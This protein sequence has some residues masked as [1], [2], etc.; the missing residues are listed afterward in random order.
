MCVKRSLFPLSSAFRTGEISTVLFHMQAHTHTA[1]TRQSFISGSLEAGSVKAVVL[2]LA[3][4]Y[5]KGFTHLSYRGHGV[6]VTVVLVICTCKDENVPKT[7]LGSKQAALLSLV[8]RSSC[9]VQ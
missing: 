3:P 7:E 1:S 8:S 5:W 4:L 9:T 6:L 2:F